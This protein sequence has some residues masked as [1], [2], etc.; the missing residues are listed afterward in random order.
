MLKTHLSNAS[1]GIFIGLTLSIVFSFLNSPSTYLPLSPS[2]GVGKWMQAHDVHGSLVMLYCILIWAG[3]GLLFSLGKKLFNKDWSLLRATLSHYLLMLF[4]FLPLATLGGWF[5]IQISFY[6]SVIIEF[7]LVYL[8]IWAV[9][10]RIYKKKVE[11]INQ[12]LQGK[13]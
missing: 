12:Q 9:S 4:G 2:S 13:A 6:I 3:I 5:P 7:S 11:E 1:K 8:V 10:Y